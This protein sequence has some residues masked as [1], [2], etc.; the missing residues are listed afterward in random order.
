MAIFWFKIATLGLIYYFINSYNRK[1]YYYYL[2]LGVSKT[3]LWVGSL[4]IDLA[5]FIFLIIF[6]YIIK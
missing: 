3:L 6:T 2:N 1:A 4:G 5:L